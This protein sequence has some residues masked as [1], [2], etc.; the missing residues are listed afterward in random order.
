MC[1]LTLNKVRV[2]SE[3]AEFPRPISPPAQ[4]EELPIQAISPPLPSLVRRMEHEADNPFR[5]EESLYHEV[6]PIVKAYSKRPFP[7][8][9][10][11]S[12]IPPADL[13]PIKNGRHVT[14]DNS[15]VTIIDGPHRASSQSPNHN[16]TV[17]T[18]DTSTPQKQNMLRQQ[19]NGAQDNNLPPPKH[20]AE[21][22]HLDG[23][24]KKCACCSIQ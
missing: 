14:L 10:T 19:G 6:D 3:E 7:P 20:D 13:T 11:G 5:P 12:P 24:K 4:L 15:S 21:V 8:S 18:F 9:P 1:S 16:A 23:K 2:T 22:V 17:T